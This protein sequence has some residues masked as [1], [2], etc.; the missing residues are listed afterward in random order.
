MEGWVS[1]NHYA[2]AVGNQ[3]AID[4]TFG[5]KRRKRPVI[6]SLGTFVQGGP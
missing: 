2:S 4:I 3:N 6:Y 5:G 1:V